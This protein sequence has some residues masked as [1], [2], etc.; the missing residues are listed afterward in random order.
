MA[1]VEKAEGGCWLWTA[2]GSAYPSIRVAGG[3]R[4]KVHRVAWDIFRGE[5]PAGQWVLHAPHAVCGSTRCV[6]PEHLHL[7]TPRDNTH[8]SIR[9]GTQTGGKCTPI[10]YPD[11]K[12]VEIR[13]QH[14]AGIGYKR[15]A[16]M[17][18]IDRE[19][20]RDLVKGKWRKSAGG[21]GA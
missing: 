11:E 1:G 10:K 19:Y 2:K 12:I 13:A 18:G 4:E 7:G 9:D 8:D 3:R 20:V 16:K 21:M 14:Q 17:H 15:L 6:N 5:I